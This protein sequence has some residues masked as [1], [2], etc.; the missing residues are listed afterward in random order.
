LAK[1]GKKTQVNLCI[2]NHDAF[3]GLLNG[4]GF[5]NVRIAREFVHDNKFTNYLVTHGDAYDL[6][7]RFYPLTKVLCFLGMHLHRFP[8][9]RW[10]KRLSDKLSV[11]SMNF[12]RLRRRAAELGAGGCVI[13]HTHTPGHMENGFIWNCGDWVEHCT[14]IVETDQ[15]EMSLLEFKGITEQEKL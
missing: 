7:L 15:H 2:G 5:G 11:R 9:T 13:G 10:V 8:L 3:F 4:F 14:A 1:V 6:G 12:A